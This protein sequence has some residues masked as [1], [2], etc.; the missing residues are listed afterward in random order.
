MVV[1]ALFSVLLFSTLAAY[2]EFTQKNQLSVLVNDL[3]HA[4]NYARA[5]AI[6]L[7]AGITFCANNGIGACGSDWQ[8]GQI[9]LNESNQAVLYELPALPSGYHLFWRSTLG[10]SADLR[11]RSDGFTRGQQGSFF[12]C[13]RKEHHER[14]AQ[15]I[16]LRTGRIR[17]EMGVNKRISSECNK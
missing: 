6:T 2:R 8:K 9:I 1:I 4:L 12:V 5:S 17:V 3:T 15:I 11:W 10:D 7:Q 16:I 13:G 14:S